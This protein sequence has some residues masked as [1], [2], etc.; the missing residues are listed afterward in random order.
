MP[1]YRLSA[2]VATMR[3]WLASE[4]GRREMNRLTWRKRFGYTAALAQEVVI[5]CGLEEYEDVAAVVDE[6]LIKELAA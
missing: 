5:V 6:V 4:E 3:A 1:E 2:H